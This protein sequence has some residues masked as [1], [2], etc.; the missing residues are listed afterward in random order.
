MPRA[1]QVKATTQGRLADHVAIGLLTRTY[2]P[3]LVDQVVAATGKAERRHR[4]LPA[5][6]VV[7]YVLAMAL[8]SH[9]A[10]EEVMRLLV[11]GLTWARR[12]PGSWPVPSKASIFKARARLGP[13]PLEALFRAAARPLAT[14]ATRGAWYRGWRLVAIDGTTFDV[15]DTVANVAAFGRPGVSRGEGAAYP[16]VRLVALAECGTHAV[17]GAALGPVTTGETTLA[18]ELFGALRP[19]MLLLA[20]RGFVGFELWRRAA[21][22][23]AEL[24]WRARANASLEPVQLLDDGSYLSQIVAAKDHHQ[25][26]D[27]ATVRVVEYTLDDPGRVAPDGPY[28][29]V[30]TVLDPEAAPAAELAAAY[31]ERWELETVLDELK[32]HQCGPRP[33]LRSKTPGGV[34][35]E[36][37]GHLLTHYAVR[38]LM[39]D[40][41][42]EADVDPDRCSFTTSLRVVRRK[43]VSGA[44]FS[45]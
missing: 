9:A 45:P 40:A 24:L 23:G 39:H 37:Y 34:V 41:A 42:A 33:V 7:Y 31:A 14:P 32:T 28:R 8:F 4:L 17:V 15:A 18:P 22:T 44:G 38:A 35:Q 1:G 13:E 5:R 25:R 11:E 20:D 6:V 10:Y 21:A 30:T 27:P 2:P 12:W 26:R 43:M 16:Q 36:V 19:G 29:L 3:A